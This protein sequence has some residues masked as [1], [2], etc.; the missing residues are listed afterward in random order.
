[1][2]LGGDADCGEGDGEAGAGVGIIAYC[3]GALDG[4]NSTVFCD[5]LFYN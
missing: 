1:M 4:N 2:G 3:R 5:D